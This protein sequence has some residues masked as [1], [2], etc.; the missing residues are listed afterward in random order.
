MPHFHHLPIMPKERKASLPGYLPVSA[1]YPLTTT[2]S[3][4]TR[5]AT[6][7]NSA[8]D[9]ILLQARA[10]GLNWGPIH[11]RHFPNKTPNACRKRHERLIEKRQG[12]DWD[13]PKL[14]LLAQEYAAVRKEM[15][16]VLAARLGEKWSLVEAKVSLY[17]NNRRTSTPN[18]CI[19]YGERSEDLASN[20]SYSTQEE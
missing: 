4:G 3:A 15:W 10:S 17:S 20:C 16:E 9:E 13:V 5:N 12:E 18:E 2:S 19:V 6:I 14:E 11:Q 8:D 1:P 7:W